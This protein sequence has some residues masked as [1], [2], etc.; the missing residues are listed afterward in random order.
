MAQLQAVRAGSTRA[1]MDNVVQ[2]IVP[3]P[4]SP[5]SLHVHFLEINTDN[6]KVLFLADEGYFTNPEHSI[7]TED[8]PST[9]TANSKDH[10]EKLMLMT[11]QNSQ[12]PE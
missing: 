2:A 1:A 9:M 4:I 11:D 6:T 7:D 3:F 12:H 10:P 8:L 5:Q